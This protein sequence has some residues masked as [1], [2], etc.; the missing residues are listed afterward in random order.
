M[1][2]GPNPAATAV[3][4]RPAGAAKSTLWWD[5]LRLAASAASEALSARSLRGVLGE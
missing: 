2:T 5:L 3:V 1:L 4:V